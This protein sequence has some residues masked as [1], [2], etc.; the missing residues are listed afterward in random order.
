MAE[1]TDT[2]LLDDRA[3]QLALGLD[4][5]GA[6]PMRLESAEIA[7]LFGAAWG[8]RRARHA[9]QAATHMEAGKAA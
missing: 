5:L 3:T 6:N 4:H 8:S 1:P 9:R 7:L 2:Q